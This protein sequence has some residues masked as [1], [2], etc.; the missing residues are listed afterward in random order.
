[1]A[2]TFKLSL[3]PRIFLNGKYRPKIHQIRV[4]VVL[5]VGEEGGGGE[6][7][8][9]HARKFVNIPIFKII[10]ITINL[11]YIFMKGVGSVCPFKKH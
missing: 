3:K 7:L 4:V 8:T 2:I 1:M 11:I 6:N 5:C 10:I 9:H